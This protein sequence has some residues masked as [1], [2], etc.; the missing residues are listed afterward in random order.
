MVDVEKVKRFI[1]DNLKG[2][3][4]LKEI[5]TAFRKDPGDLDRAFRNV[6]GMTIKRYIDIK[7]K[8]K[9]Q[10]QLADGGV[11]GYELANEFG[12]LSEQSFYRWSRR[13]FG[14]SFS[15]LRR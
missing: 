10:Q 11:K 13:V 12:F 7:L 4:G 5:S 3:L 2:T 15:K 1:R 6:E 14:S 8:E 9:V